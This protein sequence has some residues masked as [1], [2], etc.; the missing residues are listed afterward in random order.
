MEEIKNLR[1]IKEL[2]YLKQLLE[3][4]ELNS[5]DIMVILNWSSKK[6]KKNKEILD[7]W[8]RKGEK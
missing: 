7:E 1:E 6:R 5:K 8:E 4:R 2:T 3:E